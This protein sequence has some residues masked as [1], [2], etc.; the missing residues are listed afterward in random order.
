MSLALDNLRKFRKE[1]TAIYVF[2]CTANSENC[3]YLNVTV[4]VPVVKKDKLRKYK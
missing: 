3:L 2:F 4:D 1:I